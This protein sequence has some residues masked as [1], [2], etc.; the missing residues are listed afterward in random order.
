MGGFGY[1]GSFVK[2]GDLQAGSHILDQIEI[3]R[4]AFVSEIPTEFCTKKS[5][6]CPFETPL[7]KTSQTAYTTQPAGRTVAIGGNCVLQLLVDG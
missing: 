3:E 1:G 6:S 5:G 4:D 2:E 7:W